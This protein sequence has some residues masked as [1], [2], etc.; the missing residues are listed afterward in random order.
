MDHSGGL[1][2][3]CALKKET[4]TLKSLLGERSERHNP[5]GYLV[6]G[7]GAGR[8]EGRLPG[9]LAAAKPSVLI[10]TGTAGQLDPSL[11]VGDVGSPE[12]WITE[13]GEVQTVSLGLADSLRG[14]ELAVCGKGLTVRRAVLSAER[15]RELWEKTGARICDMEAAAALKVAASRNIPCL[16]PK[17]VSDE[18]DFSPFAFWSNLDANLARLAAY[19]RKL[20]EAIEY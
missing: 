13:D 5:I 2:V 7:V 18:G 1:F 20:L 11:A 17:V 16:A 14:S 4:L 6:T 15:R 8:T 12:C 19:L 10:F 3:A 9:L